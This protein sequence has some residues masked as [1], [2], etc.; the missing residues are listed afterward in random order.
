[1]TQAHSM[2]PM[3]ADYI[4]GHLDPLD[5]QKMQRAIAE[6]EQLRALVEFEKRI[7]GSVRSEVHN[8]FCREHAAICEF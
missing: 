2:E 5:E 1:M 6:D 7:Q 4:N 3:I 8:V